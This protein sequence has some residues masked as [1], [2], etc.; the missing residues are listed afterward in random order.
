MK[1]FFI[2]LI[3]GDTYDVTRISIS[4]IDDLKQLKSY[5]FDSFM[6]ETQGDITLIGPNHIGLIGGKY[7]FWIKSVKKGQG[8]VRIINHRFDE[9]L[10]FH[11]K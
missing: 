3:I 9:T 7:A 11:I 5:C 1:L 10:T 6:I 8:T 2:G 4:A